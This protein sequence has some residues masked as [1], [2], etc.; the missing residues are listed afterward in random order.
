MCQRFALNTD[1]DAVGD[2]CCPD[3]KS[4]CTSAEDLPPH[5]LWQV[6]GRLYDL[7][8]FAQHH[9]G[10]H[11]QIIAQRGKDCTTLFETVHLFDEQPR[12][13]LEK[14]YVRD[15]PNYKASLVWSGDGFYPTLKRRVKEHFREVHAKKKSSL[16]VRTHPNQV[17]HGT[18]EYHAK[19]SF[20]IL[21]TYISF[22]G[23]IYGSAICAGLWGLLA[24][25]TGGVG[26]EALHAGT[27]T[28]PRRNRVACWF[29]LDTVGISSFMYQRVHT[30][31]HHLHTNE[32]GTD[33]DIEVHMPGCRLSQ[34]Q[35]RLPLHWWQCYIAFLTYL[36]ALPVTSFLDVK[37]VIT[38]GWGHYDYPLVIDR[39]R[40][41]E[42]CGFILGKLC[43]LTT[44]MSSF[45]AQPTWSLAFRQFALMV[46]IGSFVVVL[47]F[48]L[49]HQNHKCFQHGEALDMR[50]AS[51]T[52]RTDA[53][54]APT[55]NDA[56]DFGSLQVKTT[57]NFGAPFWQLLHMGG[58]AFQ[59]EHH[60]F[61]TISVCHL[62]DVSKIVMQ[63]CAEYG[64][65]YN[66]YTS[67]WSAV[68]AH[69]N[70][71][72]D[73]GRNDIVFAGQPPPTTPCAYPPR[74]LYAKRWK[75]DNLMFPPHN[76]LRGP[77]R[78]QKQQRAHG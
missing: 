71:L 4:N 76:E 16:Y 41:L 61:P 57:C 11:E 47:T 9:P 53:A 12:K 51:A 60:L 37:A 44:M 13:L 69:F 3:Q 21:G 25:A 39:P 32:R 7:E 27:F 34:H 17:H 15:I 63:A 67:W 59:I 74:P 38:G 46:F 64:L 30:F 19:M 58:L 28:T 52:A 2:E 5:Q 50:S 8:A 72:K 14:Y 1:G 24:F 78:Y 26:H 70:Y 10:G 6:H 77:L 75:I 29:F 31:G 35:E 68:L 62:P 22:I 48:A 54:N 40:P 42:L 65:P 20:F 43:F 56:A 36:V 45:V 73:M 33:P 18:P 23:A 55:E 66:Y 49:S